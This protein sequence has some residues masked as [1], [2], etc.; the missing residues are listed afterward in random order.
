MTK[1]EFLYLTRHYRSTSSIDYL[2]DH[3][4]TFCKDEKYLSK[5]YANSKDK[6]VITL[7]PPEL[8]SKIMEYS[9]DFRKQV[10]PVIVRN[11]SRLFV[12]YH[13]WVN[14]KKKPME[15][16]ISDQVDF[17]GDVFFADS[18]MKLVYTPGKDKAPIQ[19]RHMGNVVME[20]KSVVHHFTTIHRA[21]LGS[22]VIETG[23]HIGAYCNVG[24]NVL[25]RKNTALTPYVCLGGSSR[26]GENCLLGMGT[27]VRDNVRICSGVKIGMGSMVVKDITEPGVYFGSPAERRS[28]WD[29]KWHK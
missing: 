19:M 15:H 27:I 18:A 11:V 9:Q 17:Q 5:L 24:H 21:S 3:S 23:V 6:L 20:G 29:G 16:E 10:N 26:I 4:V 8:K 13:N 14:V 2:E 1:K 28:D 12:N 7:I 22:T 25:I